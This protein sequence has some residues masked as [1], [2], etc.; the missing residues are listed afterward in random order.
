MIKKKVL[1]IVSEDGKELKDL[2]IGSC[3]GQTTFAQSG[4]VFKGY[5][6]SDFENWGLDK[7]GEATEETK[8]NVYEMAGEDANYKK[9]FGSLGSPEDIALTQHQAIEFINKYPKHL[10]Q[11]G[12]ATFFLFQVDGKFFVASVCVKSYGLVVIVFKFGFDF[13]W[14]A[15]RRLRLVAKATAL[16][17]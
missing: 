8:V 16:T 15:G 6:D 3:D 13:V 11:G 1:Q 5:L 7:P 14:D 17:Q 12:Y 2:I 4:D 9:M 10:R